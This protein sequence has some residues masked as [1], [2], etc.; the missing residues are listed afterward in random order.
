[1]LRIIFIRM[2]ADE[3]IATRIY[4]NMEITTIGKDTLEASAK[5]DDDQE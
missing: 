4:N 3:L 2:I 5:G 1:M